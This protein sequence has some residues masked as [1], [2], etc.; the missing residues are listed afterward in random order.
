[1]VMIMIMVMMIIMHPPPGI[2]LSGAL[3]NSVATRTCNHPYCN[4]W[5]VWQEAKK[6]KDKPKPEA[7]EDACVTRPF[8]LC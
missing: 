1:M 8:A 2:A 5:S 4:P 6:R 3:G 7:R